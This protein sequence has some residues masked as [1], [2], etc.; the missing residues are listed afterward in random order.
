MHTNKV[1]SGPARIVSISQQWIR[2][3]VRSSCGN[4]LGKVKSPVE[5]GA[6]LDIMV[7]AGWD[8]LQMA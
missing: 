7:S 3:I 8:N 4:S 2:P 6:K 5:F 1:H